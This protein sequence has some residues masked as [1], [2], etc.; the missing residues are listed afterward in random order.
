[1]TKEI[2]ITGYK[3]N[4]LDEYAKERALVEIA[5]SKKDLPYTDALRWIKK[6]THEAESLVNTE[7]FSKNGFIIPL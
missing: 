3:L 6:Y 2:T 1:M 4:E 7:Y 5:M